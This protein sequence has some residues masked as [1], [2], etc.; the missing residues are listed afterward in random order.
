MVHKQYSLEPAFKVRRNPETMHPRA[1]LVII[2][3]GLANSNVS[4]VQYRTIPL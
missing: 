1:T 4:T 3:L 2:R